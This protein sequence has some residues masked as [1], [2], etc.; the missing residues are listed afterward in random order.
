MDGCS[1]IYL[2]EHICITYNAVCHPLY[3]INHHTQTGVLVHWVELL[4]N[5]MR[6]ARECF[7]VGQDFFPERNLCVYILY[8]QMNLTKGEN[9]A[10]SGIIAPHEPGVKTPLLVSDISHMLSLNG[11]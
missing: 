9:T 8:A 7:H 3:I 10:G 5:H 2:F 1:E 11:Y 4:S 6:S